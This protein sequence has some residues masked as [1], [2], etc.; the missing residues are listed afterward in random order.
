[1][2]C[3]CGCGGEAI[4]YENW[5]E[6]MVDDNLNAIAAE[7][8]GRKVTLNKPFRTKGASKKFGVYTKNANGNVVLVRFGDPNMEI[9]RDDPERRKNFRSRHNCDNPGP[10]W[11]AR[12]WS[13]RQWRGGKKVEAGEEPCGCGC[14]DECDC[15]GEC[16]CASDVRAK[17][18]DD[19]CQAGYE[20]YGMKMKGGRKVPNCVPIKKKAKMEYCASC[21]DKKACAKHGS[22]MKNKVEAAEPTPKDGETHKEYMDRCM[23]KGYSKEE[24][25]KAHEGHEFEV[26]GYYDDDEKKKKK[27]K[28]DYDSCP[29]GKEMRDGKCRTISVTLDL[30]IDE[31][32]AI[33]EATTGDTI[34]EIRGIAFHEGKNKNDWEITAEG[35]RLLAD[36]M[37]GADVTLNHPDASQ[38]GSGFTRNMDGGVNEA[39]VGYIKGATFHKTSG[40]YEVRYVAHVV[41]TELFDA[42][43][44]GLWS[45]EDYGVSIGGSGVP[46]S[47][48]EDGIVFG[49]DFTFDHLAIVH[50]PAYKRANIESVKRVK[51]SVAT[52][53]TFISHSDSSEIKQMVSAMTDETID[54]SEMENEI[55]ALKADLVLASSRVAEFEAAE[56]ARIEAERVALVEKASEM[57]MTGHEDLKAE[58]VE[59]LI[60]SW[61]ASHPTPEPVVMEEVVSETSEEAPV[62][63]SE[64]PKR[65]VA[66][67]LNGKMVESDEDIYARC[68]NAWAKAWNGTLAADETDRMRAPSYEERKEMI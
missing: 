18:K 66:N 52:E 55:E 44:S 15:D 33:V 37:Q 36:R 47:A 46:V 42:L 49:E 21:E 61:E 39:V 27:K 35:A 54:T 67:Y 1:M 32:E 3:G 65:V 38:H 58:T 10:K 34:I 48:D 8:Q 19:P 50:K 7:Y 40:G 12:Y 64:I 17:D 25:M 63:A 41:R 45:R 68:W 6:H 22:C 60:A 14:E 51:K 59:R 4:A 11:K 56:E 5:N 16:V 2:S 53:K 20:Q 62:V 57:G 43:E 23:G 28:A 13:C 26:E 29:P 31:M 24:C 30:E 9:K